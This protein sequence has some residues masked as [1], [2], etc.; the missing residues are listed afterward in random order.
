MR[1]QTQQSFL[2]ERMQIKNNNWTL[3]NLTW[4]KEAHYKKDSEQF[5]LTHIYIHIRLKC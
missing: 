3:C 5:C 1:M 2:K 4:D